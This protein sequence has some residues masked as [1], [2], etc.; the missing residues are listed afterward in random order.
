MT[1]IA[2]SLKLPPEKRSEFWS[3]TDRD[4]LFL[5]LTLL[6]NMK[7]AEIYRMVSS[8]VMTEVQLSRKASAVTTSGDGVEYLAARR[9]QLESYYF[10][11]DGVEGCENTE[12]PMSIEESIADM[13]PDAVT[14]LRAILRDKNDENYGD[15]LRLFL[16]KLI[17][18][19]ETKN[20]AQ[21]PMRY[22]P[23]TPC[24]P[25]RYKIFCENETAD[26]C[27]ICRYRDLANKQGVI[28]DYKNQLDKSLVVSK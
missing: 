19:L 1:M 22:L 27:L 11:N 15:V 21:P 6:L 24:L 8:G 28:Y 2:K 5:D 18:D 10:P 23:E 3:L 12:K 7:H 4:Y 25:C 13:L 16:A 17:K 26:E 14:N 20:I 9:L